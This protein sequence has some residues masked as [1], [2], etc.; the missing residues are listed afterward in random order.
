ML[1]EEAI[2]FTF[3][4]NYFPCCLAAE[5]GKQRSREGGD[6][7]IPSSL[8]VPFPGWWLAAAAAGK[9]CKVPTVQFILLKNTAK[10]RAG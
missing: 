5:M 1:E 4:N 3:K 7:F 2:T 8:W 6:A 10:Q 9:Y